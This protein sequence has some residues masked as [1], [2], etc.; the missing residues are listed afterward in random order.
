M[1]DNLTT[2]ASNEAESPAFLVGAVMR[3]CSFC[4]FFQHEEIGDSDFGGVYAENPSC[5]NY[6]DT[7]EETEEDIPNFDRTIER[8]CCKLDFW[9]VVE[10]DKDL[11]EKLAIEQDKNEGSFSETYELFKVRYNYA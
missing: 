3:S 7:D 9:R 5:S 4:Q 10:V 11:S 2:N 6:F 8:N 1:N